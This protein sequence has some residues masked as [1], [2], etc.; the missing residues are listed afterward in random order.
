MAQVHMSVYYRRA[1]ASGSTTTTTATFTSRCAR[2][3]GSLTKTEIERG[4]NGPF[5][6]SVHFTFPSREVMDAAMAGDG[7]GRHNGGR[8]E[9]HDDHASAAGQR[10]SRLTMCIGGGQGLAAVFERVA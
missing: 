5:V 2:R 7:H 8:P 6:A 10:G 9:L 4:L 3:R 1:R